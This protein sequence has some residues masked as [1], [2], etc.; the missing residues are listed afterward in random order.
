[1]TVESTSIGIMSPLAYETFIKNQQN[2]NNSNHTQKTIEHKSQDDKSNKK[3]LGTGIKV[4]IGTGLVALAS[5]GIYVA[6]RGRIKA[7]KLA[8]DFAHDM[9]IINKAPKVETKF[10]GKTVQEAIDGFLGENSGIKPHTYDLSKEYPML[11]ITRYD[12]GYKFLFVT[13]DGFIDKR[14]VS[15]AC[16]HPL[17]GLKQKTDRYDSTFVHKEFDRSDAK[18]S[19]K[20]LSPNDKITPLQ[21]DLE[22][23][24]GNQKL[25]EEFA[26]YLDRMSQFK[27]RFKNGGINPLNSSR[28]EILQNA[29]LFEPADY[30]TF[31][32]VIQTLANKA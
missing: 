3:S 32:S 14:V 4:A 7:N 11:E 13:P 23:I 8:Q 2:I 26:E 22:K 31:L 5:A 15:K 29:H 9:D 12:E 25:K 19:I 27:V 17:T 21:K 24:N 20:I 30:D 18:M 16:G 28:E 6:T 1:M 10:K